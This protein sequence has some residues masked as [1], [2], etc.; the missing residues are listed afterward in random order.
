MTWLQP[1]LASSLEPGRLHQHARPRQTPVDPKGAER[2]AEVVAD[3]RDEL[4][5]LGGDPLENGADQVAAP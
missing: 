5:H 3:Q 2:G 4:R 1:G